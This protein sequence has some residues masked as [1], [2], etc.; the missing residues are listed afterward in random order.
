MCIA[1]ELHAIYYRGDIHVIYY[2][3]WMLLA[4]SLLAL[5]WLVEEAGQDVCMVSESDGQPDYG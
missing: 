2:C 5:K 3:L 1:L 4:G